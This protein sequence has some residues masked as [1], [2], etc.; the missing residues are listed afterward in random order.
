MSS[1]GFPY[2]EPAMAS[3]R[4]IPALK[5]PGEKLRLS[6]D[7]TLMGTAYLISR[8]QW[9]QIIAS[10]G[11]GIAYEEAVVDAYPLAP[12]HQKQWGARIRAMTLV[13]TMERLHEAHPS[14]RY[15]V[16]NDSM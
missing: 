11:G 15:L 5:P 13:S 14:A 2:R 8:S 4:I 16:S 6:E 1:A 9:I 10:E 7:Q 3:I 12:E